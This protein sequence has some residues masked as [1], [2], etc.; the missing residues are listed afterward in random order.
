MER[1]AASLIEELD[2]PF[3]LNATEVR[4]SASIGVAF[5]TLETGAEAL[6]SK[7]DIAM[8]HA[9]AAGKNRFVAFHAS[10]QESLQERTRLVADIARAVAHEEFFIEY[11]PI[12]D[13]GTR[14][15]LGVEA[16]LRWRHPELGV[17]MPDRFIQ[18]AEECGQIVKLGRWVLARACRELRAWR[19]S[20]A[21]GAGLRVAVNISVRHLEHGHLAEDVEHALKESGLESGN[22]V[23][24]LTESAIMHN[25]EAN[26]ARLLQLKALGVRLAIDDFG[27]GYSSLAYLHR[28]P[29]DILKIDRSFVG[30]LTNSANG[31][32][33]ARAVITLG[34][35]LGL[36]TVAEGIEFEPQVDALLRLG[37]VAGQGFLFARSASLADLSRSSFVEKRN[38]LWT[39]QAGRE[40][41]R[42]PAA[43]RHSGMWPE[44]PDSGRRRP[45]WGVLIGTGGIGLAHCQLLP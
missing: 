42:R 31:P 15:L 35:T 26:L 10:M 17:L 24:E 41:R 44:P 34:E 40:D 1:L 22:L 18:I 28:F 3:A 25:T 33:L 43:L 39:S 16:L 4:V 9:K 14:S 13:L 6:L 37:C 29:I 20:V 36:D 27:T 8:Y 38:A 45:R 7:A 5:S 12:V 11:Q 30:R 19:D 32:E 21:G 23:I 2:R